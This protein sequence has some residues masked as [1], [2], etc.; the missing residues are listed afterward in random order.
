MSPNFGAETRPPWAPASPAFDW[1]STRV[2][3]VCADG[4]EMRLRVERWDTRH[5]AWGWSDDSYEPDVVLSSDEVNRLLSAIE[6]GNDLMLV[7][8]PRRA[9]VV[10]RPGVLSVY[11]GSAGCSANAAPCS[12][13]CVAETA[14][15]GTYTI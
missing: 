4:C 3:V 15:T 6:H 8:G 7:R 1:Q 11:M 5:N 12:I 2:I 14:R 9:G 13:A 10:L